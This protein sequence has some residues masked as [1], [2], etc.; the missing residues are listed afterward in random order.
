MGKDPQTEGIKR[1]HNGA[2]LVKATNQRVLKIS[3]ED[4]QEMSK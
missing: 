3:E 1:P 4:H 2:K